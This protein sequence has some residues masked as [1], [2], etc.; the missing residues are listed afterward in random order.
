MS[1]KSKNLNMS[2]KIKDNKM[3]NFKKKYKNYRNNELEMSNKINQYENKINL[4]NLEINN[5]KEVF[6]KTKEYLLLE[7]ET[8]SDKYNQIKFQNENIYSDLIS[9]LKNENTNEISA[10]NLGNINT[11]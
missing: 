11:K 5:F 9:F 10:K 6:G 2:E 7:L 1:K 8:N 4:L 3:E